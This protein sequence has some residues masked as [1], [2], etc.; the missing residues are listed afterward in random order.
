M[1]DAFQAGL[2][3]IT[4]LRKRDAFV[5]HWRVSIP[6]SWRN[7]DRDVDLLMNDPGIVRSRAKILAVIGNAG[8]TSPCSALGRILEI[9][10]GAWPAESRYAAMEEGAGETAFSVESPT[11]S[12][13]AGS[14]SSARRRLRLDAGDGHR[15]RSRG[16]VLSAARVAVRER[17]RGDAGLHGNRSCGSRQ[18]FKHVFS[19]AQGNRECRCA[20]PGS[21]AEQVERSLPLVRQRGDRADLRGIEER[22]GHIEE[23]GQV[24]ETS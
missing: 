24:E 20:R 22:F 11:R 17:R 18:V 4:I 12:K 15:R 1:L 23:R 8:P 3:W 6:A 5:R 19:G 2:A 16:G 13:S 7:S 9:R 10:L 21:R 14:S